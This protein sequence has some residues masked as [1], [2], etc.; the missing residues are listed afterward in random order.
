MGIPPCRSASSNGRLADT[1]PGTAGRRWRQ[2]RPAHLLLPPAGLERRLEA[3]PRP[4]RSGYRH[5]LEPALLEVGVLEAALRL[6]GPSRLAPDPARLRPS[7]RRALPFRMPTRSG[8]SSLV[9]QDVVCGAVPVAGATRN[10]PLLLRAGTDAALQRRRLSVS[11]L[12]LSGRSR[13]GAKFDPPGSPG[14]LAP[15]IL[16]AYTR[17]DALVGVSRH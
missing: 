3:P 16:R 11:L 2:T 10:V 1:S 17:E 12:S 14:E 6:V 7:R 4:L 5:R 15:P 8:R 13:A 9:P